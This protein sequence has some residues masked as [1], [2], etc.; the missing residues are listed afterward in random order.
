MLWAALFAAGFIVCMALAFLRHPI[1]G[2]YFY[3]IATYLHPP[4]RWWNQYLPDLRWSMIVAILTL[5]AVIAHK[6]RQP[7][8]RRAWAA[9]VPG[10]AML[11]FT[12]WLWI[13]MPWA[14]DRELH[15]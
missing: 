1:Y 5:V 3:I 14:L 4:S 15:L 11:L 2:V 12:I 8:E 6:T 13:Q 9:T 10:L 7:G